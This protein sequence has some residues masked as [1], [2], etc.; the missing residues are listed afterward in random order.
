VNTVYSRSRDVLWRNAGDRVVL[1]RVDGGT[2]ISI[3]GSGTVLWSL[4]ANPTTFD[5]LVAGMVAHFGI[6][7]DAMSDAVATALEDL[8]R[9]GLVSHRPRAEEAAQ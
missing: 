7:V 8:D 9:A 6:D 3:E 2:L 5:D 1:R 4:L